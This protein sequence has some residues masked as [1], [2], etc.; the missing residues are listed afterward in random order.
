MTQWAKVSA[1]NSDDLS[2]ISGTHIVERKNRCLS[3]YTHMPG[4]CVHAHTHK[5]TQNLK[6]CNL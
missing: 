6:I 4:T 2:F 5:S 3:P 1:I